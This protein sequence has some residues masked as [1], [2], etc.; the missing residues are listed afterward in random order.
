MKKILLSLLI[1]IVI[2]G[3]PLWLYASFSEQKINSP[4]VEIKHFSSYT[5]LSDDE[6]VE[7]GQ[8]KSYQFPPGFYHEDLD[9][10]FY[11][12]ST[13]KLLFTNDKNEALEWMKASLKRSWS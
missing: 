5:D 9:R 7:L 10:G 6:L 1:V 13:G 2:L 3:L 8:R 12:E 4:A 11:Y